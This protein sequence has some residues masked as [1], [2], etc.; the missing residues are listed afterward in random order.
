MPAYFVVE[1]ETTNPAGMEPYRAAVPA[2]LA[3]YG[4]RFLTRGGAT[5]LIEGGPEPKRIVILEFADAAA[6]KRW[7]HSPEYQRIL[8]LRLA[9]S[10]GRAF[11]VEGVS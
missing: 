10:T 5:E 9:N 8:P 6:V 3:Q 11:V 2:T 4:G 1:V 7:Y